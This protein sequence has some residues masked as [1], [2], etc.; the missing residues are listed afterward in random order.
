MGVLLGHSPHKEKEKKMDNAV[1]LAKVV[2][3]IKNIFK[4]VKIHRNGYGLYEKKKKKEKKK[5]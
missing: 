3:R 2:I 4:K 5:R 1:T